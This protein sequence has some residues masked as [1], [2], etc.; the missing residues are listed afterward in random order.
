MT[1]AEQWLERTLDDSANRRLVIPEAF[2]A[3]DGILEILLNVT[4]GLVVYPKVIETRIK[5]ELPFM[6]TENILMAAVKAGGNRQQ[7]HEKIRVHSHAAAEQVKKFGKANDLIARLKND[8]AFS[9]VDFKKVLN[10]ADYVGRAPQQV[11][12]F[13]AEVVKP[14]IRKYR[15]QINKKTELKV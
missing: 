2:L 1:A 13:V 12:E 14:A 5:S 11:D 15:G 4:G 7:L 10:P 6:A 3:A 9:K 8:P